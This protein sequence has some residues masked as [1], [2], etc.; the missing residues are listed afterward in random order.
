MRGEM[1]N[2]GG[3]DDKE[4]RD[5]ERERRE[6]R[7][8]QDCGSKSAFYFPPGSAFSRIHSKIICRCLV[9]QLRCHTW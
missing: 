7:I 1:A 4:G 2:R 9:Y 3:G 5:E 6:K 8:E